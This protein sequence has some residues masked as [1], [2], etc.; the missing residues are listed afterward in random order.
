MRGPPLAVHASAL[1]VAHRDIVVPNFVHGVVLC[2]FLCE[3][4]VD[5]EC[6]ILLYP[7]EK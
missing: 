2:D 1:I 7:R 3:L 4:N 5:D 6:A